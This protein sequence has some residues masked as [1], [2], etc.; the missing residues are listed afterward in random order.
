[1]GRGLSVRK[2]R[3]L[4]GT[5]CLVFAHVMCAAIHGELLDHSDMAG[6]LGE[7]STPD[8]PY[9]CTADSNSAEHST[10]ILEHQS[11]ATNTKPCCRTFTRLACIHVKLCCSG[12]SGCSNL[13]IEW[14]WSSYCINPVERQQ[15]EH[16]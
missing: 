8:C 3:R 12:M 4:K 9:C 13:R 14:S 11:V 16:R 10:F 2:E 5:L 7:P 1:M 6:G 15:E